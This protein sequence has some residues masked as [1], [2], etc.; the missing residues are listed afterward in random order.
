MNISILT[1]HSLWWL[2]PIVLMAAALVYGQYYYKNPYKND[3]SPIRTAALAVLRALV[4]IGLLFLLLNPRIKY[5][6]EHIEKPLLIWAQDNSQS[7]RFCKDSA[8]YLNDYSK[9]VDAFLQKLGNKYEVQKLGFGQEVRA[10]DHF[11]F[12]DV[13]SDYA[14]LFAYL[15]NN[16]QDPG[17]TQV[18]LAGDALY[19]KGNDPRFSVQEIKSPIH[20]LTLGDAATQKDL[21]IVSLRSNKLA[22]LNSN[23]P[24][25]VGLKADFC[26]GEEISMRLY[27][28]SELLY[29]DTVSIS[30]DAFFVEKD[31]FIS[32]RRIGLQKYQ[33]RVQPLTGEYS[34]KNNVRDFVVD[35]LDS[36]RKIAICYDTYHPDIAALNSALS[37]QANFSVNLID[38]S[39]KQ[40]DFSDFNLMILY[41]L[42]STKH[43]GGNFFNQLKSS[44][45]PFMMILGGASDIK[46]L[47]QLDLGLS[48][49]RDNELFQDARMEFDASFS[50]FEMNQE[51]KKNIT[52]FPPLMSPMAKYQFN[53]ESSVLGTQVIKGILTETPLVVFMQRDQQKQ[54]Y[55]LGEGLWRWKLYDYKMNDSHEHFNALIN[56]MVQYLAL[57]VKRNQLSLQYNKVYKESDEINIEAQL[58]NKSYQA[59]NKADIKFLLQNET[60]E[61]F[62]YQFERLGNVYSLDLSNL[63]AG[64]YQFV[65]KVKAFDK[66]LE[67]RGAFVV[68]AVNLE[69]KNLQ[70]NPNLLKQLS[71]LSNGIHLPVSQLSQLSDSL[72]INK[73]MRARVSVENNYSS[74]LDLIWV[75][76]FVMILLILEWFL[77]KYWIGI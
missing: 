70:A 4:Y 73:D 35:V 19:N 28:G 64:N 38:I 29:H 39:K 71:E 44:R 58:Y 25:R 63:P 40:V 55:V 57:R 62:A 77:R 60:G 53:Q 68:S 1:E 51:D 24:V 59:T 2:L 16:V 5:S 72:L 18:I 21:S 37:Q 75:L 46:A 45:L 7:L 52:A 30:S 47:N 69:A 42:P 26:S 61:E 12:T 31:F 8:Y 13:S 74:T 36:K 33:L 43:T 3:L 9:D 34:L 20:S 22:F 54:A 6:Q 49:V 27:S 48:L 10:V 67:S 65:A 41:Q 66:D 56:R 23:T 76:C 32:P 17:Q 15:K 50:L 11:D 14:S